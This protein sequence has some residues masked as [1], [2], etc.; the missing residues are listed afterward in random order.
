MALFTGQKPTFH[1]VGPNRL[2]VQNNSNN[3]IVSSS[4]AGSRPGHGSTA[5]APLPPRL[6]P[7]PGYTPVTVLVGLP[8][9]LNPTRNPSLATLQPFLSQN[10]G[11]MSSSKP[12]QMRK[13]VF[14]DGSCSGRDH[15][16]YTSSKARKGRQQHHQKLR[17]SF[18]DK[19]ATVH[20]D[21]NG[22]NRALAPKSSNPSMPNLDRLAKMASGEEEDETMSMNCLNPFSPNY[23]PNLVR[24]GRVR[25]GD[26]LLLLRSPP[27]FSAVKLGEEFFSSLFDC[28]RAA[29]ASSATQSKRVTK[30]ADNTKFGRFVSSPSNANPDRLAETLPISSSSFGSPSAVAPS[31]VPPPGMKQSGQILS[32]QR[33]GVPKPVM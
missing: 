2:A 6:A 22:G 23:C 5:A 32:A 12:L 1:S 33:P 3:P 15:R 26:D 14:G 7:P 29:A 11:G 8:A 4:V 17:V 24:G 21:E 20:R 9:P 13:T 10:S 27:V 30:D 28:E 18:V 31:A 16:S 25:K 19:V